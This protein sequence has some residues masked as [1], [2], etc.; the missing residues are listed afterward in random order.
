MEGE[1][2]NAHSIE[3]LTKEEDF[4]NRPPATHMT[5][6]IPLLCVLL[7]HR[8]TSSTLCIHIL[9]HSRYPFFP[10]FHHGSS[11]L[12]PSSSSSSPSPLL[13]AGPD[14]LRRLLLG[15]KRLS[16]FCM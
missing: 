6:L 3:D 1:A 4:E 7:W 12:P 15:M 13:L 16:G 11:C 8:Y 10:N 9:L 2:S 5:E 14:Q